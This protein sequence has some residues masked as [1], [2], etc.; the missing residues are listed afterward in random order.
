MDSPDRF[1]QSLLC[2]LRAGA[3]EELVGCRD[4]RCA[5]VEWRVAR[6]YH[7]HFTRER[8]IVREQEE[9]RIRQRR[10]SRWRAMRPNVTQAGRTVL[11]RRS[12]EILE[13]P[14]LGRKRLASQ[15]T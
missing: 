2:L 5:Q 8:I 1:R 3:F 7:L 13:A 10:R 11:D 4:G 12:G 14:A 9:E 6:I 15:V